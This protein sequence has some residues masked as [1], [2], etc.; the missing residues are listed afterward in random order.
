MINSLSPQLLVEAKWEDQ[1]LADVTAETHAQLDA[2]LSVFAWS[3]RRVAVA[4]GS[5]GIDKIATVARAAVDW[6]KMRGADP[7]VIPAMGSHGGATPE[8]Q[9]E[10]LAALGVT[11]QSV[12]APIEPAMETL[13]IGRSSTGARVLTSRA[14]YE[15]DAVLIINRIKPHTDFASPEIGSGLRKMCVIG[16]G[17]AE[18]AF[19]FHHAATRHGYE[20]VLKEI[21]A[22]ILD[23]YSSLFGLALVEDARHHLARIEALRGE[24]IIEREPQLFAVARKWMPA[25]PFPEIDVLIVDEMGKNIS[26]AGMDTNIIERGIDGVPRE[27]RKAEVR[28]IYVRS[29]TPES[30]GNAIGIGLADVASSSL[31]EKID[32]QATYTNALT[33]ISPE[34]VRIPMHFANDQECLKAAL[35]ISGADPALARIVRVR[36]TLA[37]DKFIVT[38]NYAGEIAGR[39][40]LHILQEPREWRFTADGNFDSTSDLLTSS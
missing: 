30:H 20:P 26:G 21:S 15:A 36:N 10:V 32:K 27:G 14:A 17:K 5:R 19:E 22:R 35:R 3:G 33:A 13:E 6:F 18:G 23:S 24:R 4:V 9:K 31:V 1:A 7:F 2:E 16:L 38:A 34:T 28:A 25:L 39:E 12:G 29:L 40:G 37:L 8:G 11:E